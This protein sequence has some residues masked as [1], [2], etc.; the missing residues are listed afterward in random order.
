MKSLLNHK[1]LRAI[2]KSMKKA[3][4]TLI[5]MLIVMSIVALC[6]GGGGFG[7]SRV[8]NKEHF[9]KEA[10]IVLEQIHLAE[11]LMIN[12]KQ[13]VQIFFEDGFCKLVAP[14]HTRQITLSKVRE[15][16]FNGKAT[17][18]F[19]DGSLGIPPK[20]TL[21]LRGKNNEKVIIFS[22]IP[23]KINHEEIAVHEA[24]YPQE[25]LSLT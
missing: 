23:G 11:E 21:I 12:T 18:L 24:S 9:E 22:G 4:F 16:L 13:D 6:L 5:E 17:S 19:F 20:G 1:N 25:I 14:K 3:S 10:K 7:I 15:V 8:L 2:S